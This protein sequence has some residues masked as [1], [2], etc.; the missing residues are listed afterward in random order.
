MLVCQCVRKVL[1][2]WEK[3]IVLPPV[4]QQGATVPHTVHTVLEHP[5]DLGHLGSEGCISGIHLH[6]FNALRKKNNNNKIEHIHQ[7]AKKRCVRKAVERPGTPTP[8]LGNQGGRRRVGQ[9]PKQRA[10]VG[11]HIKASHRDA[12]RGYSENWNQ[13][14][15]GW[16]IDLDLGR[17]KKK[18]FSTI[19]CP[20]GLNE[21]RGGGDCGFPNP[22]P[23]SKGGPCAQEGQGVEQ[24][25]PWRKIRDIFGQ[26]NF[27]TY[28]SAGHF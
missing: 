26:E 18:P 14:A 4:N 10:I 15:F 24:N 1:L 13:C 3:M 23:P 20:T 21:S 27:E 28:F 2:L 8:R 22:P 6:C 19:P 25:F 9:Q 17:L 7:K 12:P 11:R 16:S 5:P